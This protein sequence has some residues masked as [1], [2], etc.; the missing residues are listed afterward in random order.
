MDAAP[1]LAQ[2]VAPGSI[3]ASALV[4]PADLV[5]HRVA[6]TLLVGATAAGKLVTYDISDPATPQKRA[7]RDLGAPVI[8]LRLVDGV[9][10]AV[11]AQQHVEAFAIGDA[12]KLDVFRPAPVIV[13]AQT[14]GQPDAVKAVRAV[15]GKVESSRHGSL[16]VELERAGVVQPGDRLLVR[17]QVKEKRVNPFNG[18]EEEV[19]SNAP[20]A[21]VEVRKVQGTKALADLDRGDAAHPG[22]SVEVT[23]RPSLKSASSA[24]R[25]GFD[26]Y[27]RAILRPMFNLGEINVASLTEIAAGTYRDWLHLALRV[28]PLGLSVPNPVAI[29]NPHLL[30]GYDAGT[31]EFA[32]G[33]GYMHESRVETEFS[34]DGELGDP[35]PPVRRNGVTVQPTERKCTRAGPTVVQ[36]LRLGTIDGIHLQLT[37]TIVTRN[38]R[39]EFGGIDGGFDLPLSR[40]LN[41]YGAAGGSVGAQFGELGVRTYLHGVGARETLI[42]TTGVGGSRLVATERFGGTVRNTGSGTEVTQPE[43]SVGGIHLA[44]GLEYRM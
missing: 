22:D 44:V 29:A 32:I 33:A 25:T 37:N 35:R 39:F 1:A 27:A 16:I 5:I 3:A 15:V 41:L 4:L 20:V 30:V 7:E 24:P 40:S 17:S 28:M 14:G 38:G 43:D 26:H 34:C 10:F 6:G 11:V 18:K 31:A 21:V 42:L 19:L 12:G 8:D 23:E 36:H 13:Q 9:V 2:E